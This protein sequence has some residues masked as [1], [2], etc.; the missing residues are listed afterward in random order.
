MELIHA[1]AMD[2][3]QQTV[4]SHFKMYYNKNLRLSSQT[5]TNKTGGV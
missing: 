5:R 2:E 3:F 1:F 4:V